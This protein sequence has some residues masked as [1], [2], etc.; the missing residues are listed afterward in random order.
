MA[1]QRERFLKEPSARFMKVI[2]DGNGEI[3][4]LAR[5]H[6]SPGGYVYERDIKWEAWNL[7]LDGIEEVGREEAAGVQYGNV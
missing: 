7:V 5:W 6:Y 1:Y 3:I 4:C 2:D